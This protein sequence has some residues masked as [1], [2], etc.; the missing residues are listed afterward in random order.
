MR[1]LS[2]ALISELNLIVTRPGYFVQIQGMI[3]TN[4]TLYFSTIGAV[5]W[6]GKPWSPANMKVSGLTRDT[7]SRREAAVEFSN[8]DGTYSYI[9]LN[10]GQTNLNVSIWSVYAGAPNDAVLEFQGVVNG[11]T[12][13]DK[14]VMPLVGITPPKVFLP[15]RRIS[16]ASGFNTLIASG[17]MLRVGAA[18]YQLRPW[19][20][21][22]VG[23]L[24]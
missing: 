3:P 6:D 15:R 21:P 4:T 12:V 18:E 14:V 1:T 5:S 22:V 11:A 24:P 13:G 8:L 10:M 23:P 20:S 19:T 16:V 2:P 7:S 9:A 17:T